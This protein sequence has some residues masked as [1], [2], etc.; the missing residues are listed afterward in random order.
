MPLIVKIRLGNAIRASFVGLLIIIIKSSSKK[1]SSGAEPLSLSRVSR[2][3][4]WSY[5]RTSPQILRFALSLHFWATIVF[6][7]KP[8]PRGG[9]FTPHRNPRN[10]IYHQALLRKRKGQQ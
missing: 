1:K 2:V 7:H 10:N 8:T 4:C 9:T 6:F 5:R 3:T